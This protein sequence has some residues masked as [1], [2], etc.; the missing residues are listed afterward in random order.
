MLAIARAIVEQRRLLLVDEPT[1]GL[2]PVVVDQL[3]EALLGLKN[4]Q[5]TILLV[6]QNFRVALAIGDD[7]AVM[8]QGRIVHSGDMAALGGDE[9]LQQRLL[10]LSMAV[11]T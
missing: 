4:E 9:E 11:G 2:S 3:V 1:K 6:E 10:G 5:T 8:D 7:V